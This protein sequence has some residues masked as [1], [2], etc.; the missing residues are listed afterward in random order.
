MATGWLANDSCVHI[1]SKIEVSYHW[2]KVLPKNVVDFE[3][4]HTI[5]AW[6]I[7]AVAVQPETQLF[8]ALLE[9]GRHDA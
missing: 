8:D 6:P 7:V 4:A 2:S 1:G 9:P 3:S 5:C